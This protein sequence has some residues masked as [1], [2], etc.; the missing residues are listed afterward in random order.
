MS[1]YVFVTVKKSYLCAWHRVISRCGGTA[2]LILNL[3]ILWGDW[4]TSLPGRFSL[5]KSPIGHWWR[6]DVPL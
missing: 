2:P 1:L 5:G 3:D 4:T 6:R